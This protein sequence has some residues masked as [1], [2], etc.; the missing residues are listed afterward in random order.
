MKREDGEEE[1]A[2]FTEV[3]QTQE[4]TVEFYCD[5]FTGFKAVLQR[6]LFGRLKFHV[7]FA[8]FY[9]QFGKFNL[10]VYKND[11]TVETRCNNLMLQRKFKLAPVFLNPMTVQEEERMEMRLQIRDN[12]DFEINPDQAEV[13]VDENFG[14]DLFQTTTFQLQP[15]PL[16]GQQ[17]SL[18]I[19]INRLPQQAVNNHNATEF[20][21][22]WEFQRPQYEAEPEEDGQNPNEDQADQENE[23]MEIGENE[24]ARIE[25]EDEAQPFIPDHNEH[26]PGTDAR[27]V[28]VIVLG[29]E[30]INII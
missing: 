23:R 16:F 22:P 24:D 2:K 18:A 14:N 11:E 6:M 8:L 15:L 19:A 30:N 26:N 3:V 5:H 20:I 27:T 1:W 29:A 4:R 10:V 9:N 12:Q 25:R 7:S 13:E 17:I 21:M 28:N